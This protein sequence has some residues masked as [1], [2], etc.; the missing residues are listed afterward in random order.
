MIL[1]DKILHPPGNWQDYLTYA[2][3]TPP[4]LPEPQWDQNKKTPRF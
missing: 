3:S 2:D 1:T 4:V